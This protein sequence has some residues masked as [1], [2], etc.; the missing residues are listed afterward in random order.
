MPKPVVVLN[1]HYS[2]LGVAR[3]L[4]PHGVPVYGLSA[5]EDFPG[6]V[7][8]FCTFRKAPDS[9]LEP[10]QLVAFLLEFRK[11][12]NENPI[13]FPTR[14]HDIEFLT[15]HREIIADRYIIPM[16]E[17][18]VIERAM[19]KD[20]CFMAAKSCDI[21]LPASWTVRNFGELEF[22]RHDLRFPVIAKPLY[23]KQWRRPGIWDV[24]N[25]QKAVQF[26]AWEDLS[27]FYR[28][29]EELDPVVTVQEY[30]PGPESNLVIFGSYCRPGGN[31]RAY[32]TA[33]KLLQLPPLR[34]TGVVVEG[35]PIP[36]IVQTSVRLLRTI[37]FEGISEIEF[38][39]HEVTG[40]PYLIEINPR[41]WDQHY[42]GTA[43]GVNLTWEWYRDIA[44]PGRLMTGAPAEPAPMQQEGAVRWVA[45]QDFAMYCLVG[46]V[47][48]RL[49][50][51]DVAALVA[52]Q[53]TYSVASTKDFRPTLR[54]LSQFV[55]QASSIVWARIS[56][57][58]T[59][60]I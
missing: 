20:Q 22:V 8:R 48:G 54:M 2:G 37:E 52:G 58:E 57:I 30:I 9:L 35:V 55:R 28:R 41:H 13:L 5:H 39:I 3:G 33:R 46:L 1:M 56:P 16:A 7:S 59:K 38:K 53:R 14:D 42:L 6:S 31:V 24:V 29:L 26:E 17:N 4:A 10:E 51:K 60:G 49:R 45:E 11:T 19:N 40:K 23:A 32:F 21:E 15:R 44:N 18:S 27:H 36:G 50:F 34:G 47:K 25:H 43:C 12:F